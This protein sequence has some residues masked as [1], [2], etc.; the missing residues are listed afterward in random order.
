MPD[1][2]GPTVH[3]L[4]TGLSTGSGLRVLA[5][6]AGTVLWARNP[7]RSAALLDRLGLTGR[8]A[9]RTL[10]G[11]APDVAPGDVVVS[12]LPADQHADVL[13]TCLARGAHF[14]CSSYVSDELVE[15]A[16]GAQRAGLVVLTEAG[17]DPGIDH[18]FAH[19]LVAR[20]AAVIGD[21][22]A[23]ADFTSYCGGV[24]AVAN[25]FRYRFS[26]SPLGV[27]KALRTPARYIDDGAER[28]VT[29]P[30][31]DTRPYVLGD[32]T[33]EVYPNRD[34]VPFVAQ[35][36]FP[37]NWRPARFVRG[38]LRLGGWRDAWAGIFDEVRAG[39]PDRLA[40]LADTLAVR[41]PM[42]EQDPDRVV[43]AVALRVQGEVAWS[44]SYGLDVVGDA[45]ESAMARCVSLPLAFGVLDILAGHRKP[46]ICHIADNGGEAA[47]CLDFLRAQGLRVT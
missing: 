25:D 12:M 9:Q 19:D 6:H 34:S 41:Y 40:G 30:W 32:E 4:G 5:G 39:D 31:T 47:R 43:L 2:A 16:A 37:A 11:V 28:V 29:E 10:A 3:W 8:V 26:W 33:F 22:P 42:T 1:P 38:T 18:V 21:R 35:Y 24:P 45:S 27:L 15:L 23:V 7:A 14:A 44:G 17:L 13:R 36:G 46:G 20:A